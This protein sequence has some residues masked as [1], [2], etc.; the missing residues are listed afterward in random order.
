MGEG[1]WQF[2]QV[3]LVVMGVCLVVAVLGLIAIARR[4][5]EI[6]VP[7]DA[8]FFTTMRYLPLIMVILLDLLDMGLDIFSAPISWIVLD[9]L[10]LPNL[11]NKAVVEA[12]IPFT[13]P[14]PTF[15]LAWLIARVFN[16][17]DSPNVYHSYPA[18]PGQLPGD[19]RVMRGNPQRQANRPPRI[20][21]AEADE[22]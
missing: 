14:V 12:L 22:R 3:I 7:P 11:R 15:T 17:G 6:R 2:F 4:I 10:G 18:N 21:D 5:R 1:L 19:A 16:L 9:R 20:I 13:G 8:D